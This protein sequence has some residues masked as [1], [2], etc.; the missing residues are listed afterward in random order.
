[1]TKTSN[2]FSSSH[3]F[4]AV[5]IVGG[6]TADRKWGDFESA[7]RAGAEKECCQCQPIE[8]CQKEAGWDVYL[9][10]KVG[11]DRL[12]IL[13]CLIRHVEVALRTIVYW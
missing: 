5:W 13:H 9:K 6:L 7:A 2:R 1:M 3:S 8:H 11:V 10:R 4:I 12:I